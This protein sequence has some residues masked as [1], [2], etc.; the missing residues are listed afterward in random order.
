VPARVARPEFP[1]PSVRIPIRALS[2][3]TRSPPARLAD[4]SPGPV[5]GGERRGV[6]ATSAAMVAAVLVAVLVLANCGGSSSDRDTS[7]SGASASTSADGGNAQTLLLK[8]PPGMAAVAL[9]GL[10]AEARDVV[11]KL[12][13]GGAFKYRQ[14]GTTFGNREQRLPSKPRGY[15][16]EYTVA[17][18][19]LSDRGPRRIIAG[20]QGE[21]YYTPDH[22]RSFEWIVRDGSP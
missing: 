4:V 6:I 19:G 21:L 16:R 18:P 7:S 20:R 12:D 8:P 14:D 17:T 13:H 9:A 5:T 22:Y 1:A 15:Y 3:P 10:P 2:V 11:D